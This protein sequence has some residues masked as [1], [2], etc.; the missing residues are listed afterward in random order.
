VDGPD[1][2]HRPLDLVH[3]HLRIVHEQYVSLGTGEVHGRAADGQAGAGEGG[4]QAAAEAAGGVDLYPLAPAPADA[5][6]ALI[7]HSRLQI[8]INRKKEKKERN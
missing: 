3:G 1:R 2:G 5:R 4:A 7:A 8:E 6:P